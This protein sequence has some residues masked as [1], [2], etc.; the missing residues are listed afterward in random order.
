VLL[1]LK[2]FSYLLRKV[3]SINLLCISFTI[4][5]NIVFLIT[6]LL[7]SLSLLSIVYASLIL[8]IVFL[9]KKDSLCF[10]VGV[11]FPRSKISIRLLCNLARS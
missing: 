9:C 3:S 7:V 11:I 4:L 2:S 1:F 5:F 10:G 8:E 6:N